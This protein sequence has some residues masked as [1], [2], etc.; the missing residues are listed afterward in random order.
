MKKTI[1][2]LAFVLLGSIS[3]FAQSNDGR[4]MV[5]ILN[6][7]EAYVSVIEDDYDM[8]IVRIECDILSDEKVTYRTLNQGWEYIIYAAGDYR[9]N[10]IDI[11]VYKQNGS[12]WVLVAKDD[13]ADSSA[14]V[15]VKPEISG[16]YAIKVKAYSLKEGYTAGHYGLIIAHE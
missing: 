2:L 3:V 1:F 9:F 10:D 16:S 5:P 15:A 12:D 14:A 6:D 4:S 8:E 11:E 7:I 13:D